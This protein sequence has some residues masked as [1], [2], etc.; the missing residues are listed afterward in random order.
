[1]VFV[2]PLVY[3]SYRRGSD[4]S[5][6]FTPLSRALASVNLAR[7]PP[8]LMHFLRPT[9]GHVLSLSALPRLLPRRRMREGCPVFSQ[10]RANSPDFS[11]PP[12]RTGAIDRLTRPIGRVLFALVNSSAHVEPRC[13][14]R[15]CG[16][17]WP[18]VA[19]HGETV[20]IGS[21]IKTV[22]TWPRFSSSLPFLLV[23]E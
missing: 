12:P 21:R 9:V 19:S 6:K 8:A 11:L 20:F 5:R 3:P 17:R 13:A 7:R 15:K 4:S 10:R 16:S 23:Q 14:S 2:S 1:M 22:P 18:R